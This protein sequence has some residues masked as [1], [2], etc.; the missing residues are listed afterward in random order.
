MDFPAPTNS[1]YTR[2]DALPHEESREAQSQVLCNRCD[3]LVLLYLRPYLIRL[4]FKMSDV[5]D[6]MDVDA[7]P[8]NDIVFTADGDSKGKRIVSDLPVEAEDNL[9]W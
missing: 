6:E 7:P 8:K 2:R 1:L 4:A 5:E 3:L 9:P